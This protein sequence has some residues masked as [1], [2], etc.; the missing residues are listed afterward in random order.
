[1]SERD[2]IVRSEEEKNRL[3]MKLFD[4]AENPVK[5]WIT[6]LINMRKTANVEEIFS[7]Y[8]D[9]YDQL[10]TRTDDIQYSLYLTPFPNETKTVEIKLEDG[11]TIERN[12]AFLIDHKEIEYS[13]ELCRGIGNM[14]EAL[15]KVYGPVVNTMNEEYK[16]YLIDIEPCFN[17]QTMYFE[18]R[19]V[20]TLRRKKQQAFNAIMDSMRYYEIYNNMP[21]D[22]KEKLD[23]EKL[24]EN[25]EK[26]EKI[27]LES[28]VLHNSISEEDIKKSEDECAMANILLNN[29]EK[30]YIVGEKNA[31]IALNDKI[32]RL[33]ELGNTFHDPE[34]EDIIEK[35][36]RENNIE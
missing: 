19:K 16:E 33:P 20:S 18:F 5:Q 22:K 31:E 7:D 9:E 25:N 13:K 28:M 14:I 35:F 6:A 10:I 34:E 8:K 11:K 27:K 29:V 4:Y 2:E 12:T 36:K 30:L 15:L 21:E 1:M 26:I 17:E 3:A 23:K 24:K 32:K